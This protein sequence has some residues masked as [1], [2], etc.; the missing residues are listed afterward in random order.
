[1]SRKFVIVTYKPVKTLGVYNGTG[2]RTQGYTRQGWGVVDCDVY[3]RPPNATCT[4][5]SL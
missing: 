4:P 3:E 5:A 2:L 1:L